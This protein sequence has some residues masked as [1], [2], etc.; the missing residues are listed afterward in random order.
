VITSNLKFEGKSYR[1]KKAAKRPSR[2]YYKK[3]GMKKEKIGA[4]ER[5]T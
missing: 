2:H 3:K 5:I 4:F 1:L